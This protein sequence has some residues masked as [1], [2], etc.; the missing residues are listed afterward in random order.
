MEVAGVSI[1]DSFLLSSLEKRIEEAMVLTGAGDLIIAN[2]R[3]IAV[4]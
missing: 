1:D 2:G 3:N 4:S